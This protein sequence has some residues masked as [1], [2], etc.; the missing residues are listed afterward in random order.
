MANGTNIGCFIP[1]TDIS[2][3][4]LLSSTEID[5]ALL[6][7]NELVPLSSVEVEVL[8]DE[9]GSELDDGTLLFSSGELSDVGVLLFGALSCSTDIEVAVL[10]GMMPFSAANVGIMVL[11]KISTA[12]SMDRLRLNLFFTVSSLIFVFT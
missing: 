11:E 5:D 4:V 6:F 12:S 3:V 9:T 1:S 10:C 7:G 8:L 2:L